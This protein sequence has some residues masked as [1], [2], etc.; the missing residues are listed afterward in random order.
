[1]KIFDKKRFIK[2]KHNSSQVILCAMFGVIFSAMIVNMFAFI[3]NDSYSIISSEYNPRSAILA[4]QNI[5]GDI[6][7]SNGEL[8]ATTI[9]DGELEERYYPYKNLFAHS[10]GYSTYGT[11]GVEDIANM[12]LVTSSMDLSD[13]VINDINK[14]KNIGDSVY[15]TFDPQIQKIASDYLG[16]YKGAVIVSEVKTGR[17]LALVSKPD[18]DPNTVAGEWDSIVNNN[19]SSEDSVLL[20]R[21]TSGLY[22][23]GS[24][25]KIVDL[26][27]YIRENPDT[28]DSYSYNCTGKLN[29]DDRKITCFHNARHGSLDLKS[30]FAKSCNCSFA[31]IGLS[32]DKQ[33]FQN[34]LSG[35]MF[36]KE[37]PLDMPHKSGCTVFDSEYDSA[38]MVQGVI[39]Q[40]ETL[41]SPI[42]LHMITNAIANDGI[43]NKPMFVDCVKSVDGKIVR[44]YEPTQYGML[45]TSE[46][47]HILQDYMHAVVEDGTA[48]TL[49]N[50]NYTAAGKTG[51]AEFGSNKGNSHAWFTGFAP[52]EDPEICITVIIENAGSGGEYAVPLAKRVFDAYFENLHKN[53]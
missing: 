37:L 16:I 44:E 5:R 33:S 22:P 48:K 13:K 31:N 14:Q 50:D 21:A 35:L 38:D 1:M 47:A 9:V 11:T 2:L 17:V 19:N 26:L 28:Y 32:F 42:H 41:V 10:V 51:S 25:F 45:M 29:Y 40:G 34:T 49:I 12:S 7:A 53:L 46:E 23:P 52:C 24:T 30:S 43:L 15:T 20:N 18:F 27:E 36:E 4:T 39:G 8:L 6:Y 3:K